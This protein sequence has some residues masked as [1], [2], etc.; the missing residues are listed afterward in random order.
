MRATSSFF[1]EYKCNIQRTYDGNKP[2]H[3]LSMFDNKKGVLLTQN[4]QLYRSQMTENDNK[5]SFLHKFVIC[6]KLV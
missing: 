2:R 3:K 5:Q 6:P 4:W 1:R